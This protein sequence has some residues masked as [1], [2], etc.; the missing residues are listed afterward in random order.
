MLFHFCFAKWAS[1]A[2]VTLAA[3]LTFGACDSDSELSTGYHSIDV[4][5][6]ERRYYLRAPA[7]VSQDNPLPLVLGFHGT[8]GS[9]ETF[10]GNNLYNLEDAVGNEALL[11]YPDALPGNDGLPQWDQAVALDFF[12]AILMDLSGYFDPWRVFVTGHSSGGG[13][14]HTLGCKRGDVIRGIA[15]VSGI[16][17]ASD[18]QGQVAVMQIHGEADNLI[19]ITNGEPSKDFWVAIN[20]CN[21][22]APDLEGAQCESYPQCD[23]NFPVWWCSHNEPLPEGSGHDWPPFAGPAIWSFFQSLDLIEPSDTTPDRE[24]VLEQT[25][26]RFSLHFPA[27]FTGTPDVAAASLYPSGTKQP[28]NASP[29]YYLNLMFDV[30]EW[31]PGENTYYEIPVT[32]ADAPPGMYTFAVNIYMKEAGT[33]PIPLPEMDYVALFDVYVNGLEELVFE[34]PLELELL[35]PF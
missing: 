2:L 1:L 19:P 7:T 29:L 31:T 18:C 26:A 8:G 16:L 11:V 35:E 21:G 14:V 13:M 33:Y 15:P 27:D 6:I 23:Q 10:I 4:N 22:E 30:G 12:D 3:G 24:F 32:T 5:G 34:T 20:G 28:L 17:L 25:M 9:A